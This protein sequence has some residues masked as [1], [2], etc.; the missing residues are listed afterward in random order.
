[1]DSIPSFLENRRRPREIRYAH[2]ILREVLAPTFGVIVYQEQ[3]MLLARKMDYFTLGRADIL[4]RA[5]SKKKND[6]MEREKSA[7]IEGCLKNNISEDIALDIFSQIEKFASYAFNKSHAAAYAELSYKTA[8]LK[9]HFPA[10]FFAAQISAFCQNSNKLSFYVTAAKRFNIKFLPPDILKSERK[11]TAETPDTILFGFCALKG[12]GDA[13][14]DEILSLRKREEITSCEDFCAK[15]DAEAISRQ[16]VE[17]LIQAGAFDRFGVS[18]RHLMQ[19]AAVYIDNVKWQKMRNISG[20]VSIFESG[21]KPSGSKTQQKIL[22]EFDEP[23]KRQFQ[24]DVLG[25][26]I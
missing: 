25:V 8:Y 4:R 15:C 17:N 22:P 14:I 7:F 2:P 13:A 1:M 9:R 12:V 18:R 5:M 3:V 23:T 24:A 26:F 6:V 20:Q 11:F 10:E 16:T 21:N 19:N